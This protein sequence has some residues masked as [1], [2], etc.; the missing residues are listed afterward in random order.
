MESLHPSYLPL[1]FWRRVISEWTSFWMVVCLSVDDDL[2][3]RCSL[4][5]CIWLNCSTRAYLNLSTLLPSMLYEISIQNFSLLFQSIFWLRSDVFCYIDHLY[6]SIKYMRQNIFTQIKHHS[7]IPTI[8][9][10]LHHLMGLQMPLL[11]IR[12][13][14]SAS[15]S[16]S[17]MAFN[18]LP[19]LH[20]KISI[21]HCVYD[22]R[23][24]LTSLLSESFPHSFLTQAI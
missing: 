21:S 1:L 8:T 11:F 15:S 5:H 19:P 24:I 2:R 14:T 4:Y 10:W 22:L 23:F 17:P 3:N 13:I 6:F 12:S 20:P 18:R 7:F 16:S 9:C